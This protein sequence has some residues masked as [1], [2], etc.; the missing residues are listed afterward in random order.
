MGYYVKRF[1]CIEERQYG[2]KANRA[3]KKAWEMQQAK[4]KGVDLDTFRHRNAVTEARKGSNINQ[5]ITDKGFKIDSGGNSDKFLGVGKSDNRVSSANWNKQRSEA[6]LKNKVNLT[7]AVNK[8]SSIP[9][10]VNNVKSA[11]ETTSTASKATKKS[12]GLLGNAGRYVKGSFTKGAL[13]GGSLGQRAVQAGTLALAAGTA[14][15]AKKF[16]DRNKG[17]KE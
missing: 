3:A 1:S 4:S 7:P 15:G 11:G 13:K 14:Y 12:G 9:P 8:T 5:R 17:S 6:K 10:S 16:Y 2:N